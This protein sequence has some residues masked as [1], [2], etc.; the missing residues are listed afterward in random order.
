MRRAL[1]R[2]AIG[3]YWVE[4]AARQKN[5]V[6][7]AEPLR[8]LQETSPQDI[9][10]L[11]DKQALLVAKVQETLVLCPREERKPVLTHEKS[12]ET[13]DNERAKNC[14]EEQAG[15]PCKCVCKILALPWLGG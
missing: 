9:C 12:N 4:Y 14:K 15:H 2:E 8:E 1:V 10:G 13:D 6:L 7:G 11:P 5:A 3:V